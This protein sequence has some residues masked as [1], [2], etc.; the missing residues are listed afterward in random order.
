MTTA[1][2]LDMPETES[3][4]FN[5]LLMAAYHET[6]HCMVAEVSGLRTGDMWIKNKFFGGCEGATSIDLGNT[7]GVYIDPDDPRMYHV[8]PEHVHAFLLCCVAGWR[9]VAH[10][11]REIQGTEE[12]ILGVSPDWG[13][14]DDLRMFNCVNRG[15]GAGLSKHRAAAEADRLIAMHWL[16]IAGSAGRLYSRKRLDASKVVSASDRASAAALMP[17]VPAE[18]QA[19]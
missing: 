8:E 4:K 7:A 13:A 14:G 1:S 18:A 5:Y 17:K 12:E 9:G 2:D 15:E 16:R 6:C 10:W 19:G 11:F 3:G